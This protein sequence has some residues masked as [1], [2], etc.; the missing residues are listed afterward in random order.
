MAKTGK[1]PTVWER[2]QRGMSSADLPLVLEEDLH[3]IPMELLMEDKLTSPPE[4]ADGRRS[5]FKSI[6]KNPL[7]QNIPPLIRN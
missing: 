7:V 5:K 3:N 2:R 1:S 6:K 4:G